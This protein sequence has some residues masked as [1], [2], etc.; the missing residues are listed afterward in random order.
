MLK[1]VNSRHMAM[2]N[3]RELHHIRQAEQHEAAQSK[4]AKMHAENKR[5]VVENHRL[6]QALAAAKLLSLT[7]AIAPPSYASASTPHP[8]ANALNAKSSQ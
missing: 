4:G 7:S 6:Q 3:D 8:T 1:Q 2:C 5:L